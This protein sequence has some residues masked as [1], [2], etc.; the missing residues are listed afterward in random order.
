MG[1]YWIGI[2]VSDWHWIGRLVMGWKIGGL[3]YD[4]HW[5]GDGLV[6]WSGISIGLEDCSSI[7]LDRWIG[8]GLAGGVRIVDG[9]AKTFW[10]DSIGW[11]FPRGDQWPY[12]CD[13]VHWALINDWS[14][15]G[16]FVIVTVLAM[17]WHR[18]SAWLWFGNDCVLRVAGSL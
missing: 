6:D 4:W 16:R 13:A 17:D 18:G 10:N 9:V 14:W 11:F 1:W 2:W 3:V 12:R 5:I 7:N 8:E 15:L